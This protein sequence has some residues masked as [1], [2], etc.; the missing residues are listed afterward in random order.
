MLQQLDRIG[1]PIQPEAMD[2]YRLKREFGRDLTFCGG[3]RTQDLLPFGTP[4]QIRAEVR[5]LKREMGTDGGYIFEPGI[6]VQGDVPL[7]NILAMIDEA[8]TIA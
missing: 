7:E 2:V 4:E 6:T 8:R 3:L 5:K 1:H